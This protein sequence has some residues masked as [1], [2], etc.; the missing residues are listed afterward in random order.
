MTIL[1]KQL[2]KK[3][4]IAIN[5]VKKWAIDDAGQMYIIDAFLNASG[6]E[7][8]DVKEA[9]SAIILSPEQN[10]IVSLSDCAAG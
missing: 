1:T 3:D 10:Y 4:V 7:T 6:N 8:V 5:L 9:V 2:M